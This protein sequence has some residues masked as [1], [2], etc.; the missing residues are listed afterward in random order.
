MTFPAKTSCGRGLQEAA[1]LVFLQKPAV[2]VVAGN[3]QPSF[4]CKSL[5]WEWLQETACSV[6]PAKVCYGS[7]LQEIANLS[8]LQKSAMGVVAGNCLLSFS[9]KSLLWEQFAGNRQLIFPAKTSCGS[10]LQEIASPVFPAKACY[11]SSLQEIANLSF[12]EKSAMR[13]V[14]RKSPAQLFMQK[15]AMKP[16]CRKLSA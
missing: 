2:G 7:S 15:P 5:L 1:N 4:S 8:F 6:F 10:G 14:Y 13:V 3:C 12:L 11:G 9:C 16:F